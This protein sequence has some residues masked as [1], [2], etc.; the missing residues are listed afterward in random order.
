[1]DMF[2]SVTFE[3]PLCVAKSSTFFIFYKI[4]TF[5]ILKMSFCMNLKQICVKKRVLADAK[6][7]IKNQKRYDF[8]H[9]LWVQIQ[10]SHKVIGQAIT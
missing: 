7:Q 8:S 3:M 2:E 1:M 6:N 10:S 5:R 4:L 9:R